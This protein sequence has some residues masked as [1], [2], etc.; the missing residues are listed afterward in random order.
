[1]PPLACKLGSF[2]VGPSTRQLLTDVGTEIH[3]WPFILLKIQHLT[4]KVAIEH[5]GNRQ[6][7]PKR[8]EFNRRRKGEVGSH[9]PLPTKYTAHA[10]TL[11]RKRKRE[12]HLYQAS[13]HHSIL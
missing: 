11:A 7:N 9:V 3:A 1:M 5:G 6:K 8:T 12:K 2:D 10:L 4:H 13:Y